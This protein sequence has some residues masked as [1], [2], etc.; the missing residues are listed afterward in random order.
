MFIF[1]LFVENPLV[2]NIRWWFPPTINFRSVQSRGMNRANKDRFNPTKTRIGT[3]PKRHCSPNQPL[4]VYAIALV[5]INYWISLLPFFA[6]SD[7]YIWLVL[8]WPEYRAWLL[9]SLARLLSF[10]RAPQRKRARTISG[11][12]ESFQVVEMGKNCVHNSHIM[13]NLCRFIIRAAWSED[14][15]WRIE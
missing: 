12:T 2:H 10:V 3:R 5:V 1:P 4:A 9:V 7:S 6:T 14:S 13:P 15:C 8:A 11:P